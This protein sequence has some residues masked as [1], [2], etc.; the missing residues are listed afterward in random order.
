[1]DSCTISVATAQNTQS[2]GFSLAQTV[3]AT[4]L[5]VLLTGELGAG[6]TTFLQGLAK[7][8]GIRETVTSP[9]YA[10]EQRYA[11]NA[12][13]L[14]H[15]DLYRLTEAQSREVVRGSEHHHGIRVIEWPQR[16]GLDFFRDEE[17]V[18]V[19]IEEARNGRNIHVVFADANLPSREQITQWRKDVRLP[20][21]IVSHCNAVTDFSLS[22]ARSLITEGRIIR[23]KA[24]EAAGLV[25]D[26]LR[27]IDFKPAAHPDGF[28]SSPED[29]HVWDEWKQ[30]FPGMKHEAA[31]AEFLRG[32]GYSVV[33]A[34]VESHGLA[35][36]PNTPKTIEQQILFY[37]D[38]RVLMDR[39]VS[40]EERFSD[41]AKRY[42][43]G[44]ASEHTVFWLEQSKQIEA[45][46]FPGG[47]PI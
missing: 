44:K 14:I 41:F 16:L 8:L 36:E 5:T 33:A 40:L 27:F 10:L 38:K 20:A 22:L 29:Q 1:M 6:K 15:I 17:R 31:C 25:H 11:G 30:R 37:A 23:V 21:H 13:D 24:L 9:T 28:T 46:L 3:Y 18:L 34:I 43:N 45:A 2:A 42:G 47:A 32:H 7:G 35:L 19:G 26:L 12:H 4:P 39:V